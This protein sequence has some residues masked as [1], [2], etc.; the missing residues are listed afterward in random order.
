MDLHASQDNA[1]S[2]NACRGIG[3]RIVNSGDLVEPIL[4][5]A[6]MVMMMMVN[7]VSKTNLNANKQSNIDSTTR[8]QYI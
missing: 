8:F 2:N 6:M 4:L 1:I 3:G 7:R 5:E